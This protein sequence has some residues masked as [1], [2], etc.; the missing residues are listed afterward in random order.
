MH[1]IIS[2]IPVMLKE[3]D[4]I[5]HLGAWT[6][7]SNVLDWDR[8]FNHY[9]STVTADEEELWFCWPCIIQT[10][11]ERGLGL[12]VFFFFLFFLKFHPLEYVLL[13]TEHCNGSLKWIIRQKLNW[14]RRN[15]SWINSCGIETLLQD[16]VSGWERRSLWGFPALLLSPSPSLSL[17]VCKEGGWHLLDN[18]CL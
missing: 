3:W 14:S 12:S 2:N 17:G 6:E 8:C 13:C 9:G 4:L 15:S 16:F 1:A 10:N 11:N 18:F 7:M 5:F